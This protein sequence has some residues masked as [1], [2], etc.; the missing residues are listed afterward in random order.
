[1]VERKT[2]ESP[3]TEA[4][5]IAEALIVEGL[6]AAA[7]DIPVV[8]EE[9]VEAGVAPAAA[10]ERRFW[11]VDPLDGTK[12]F[13]RGGEE[14]AVC[15]GLVEGGR[16]LLG[17]IAL[18]ATG[19]LFGGLVGA[20][21]WKETGDE[22]GPRRPLRVRTVPE[23]G[24]VA[25]VSR[26]YADDP[27]LARFLAGRR[28][29]ERRGLSSALKFCRV[30]EG[31]ADI[32]ARFGPTME[33]DSAA[34]QAIVEAAGGAVV[35]LGRRAAPLR[36]GGLAQPGLRLPRRPVTTRAL[37]ASAAAEAAALLRG[38]E[39]VAFPTETVYGLGADAT[40]GRA[41]AA[42][43]A[44]KGRPRFNPLICHYAEA[45]AA[46]A[47]AAPDARARLLAERF[48]PGPLTMVLPRRPESRV[49]LLTGAGLDSLAVRVP[50]HPLALALLRGAGVPV[51]APSANRSGAVS[52]TTAAH[53]LEGLGGRIAAVLDGGACPVG[54]ES[55]VLDLTGGRAALLRP[56]ACRR[57]PSKR[58]SARWIAAP[59]RRASKRRA[60]RGCWRR[61]TRPP[62]RCA[63]AR[64]RRGPTRRCS[65]SG[66][67]P[68]ARFSPG[69]CPKRATWPKRRRASSPA[70]VG[71][72]RKARASACAASPPWRCP[73]RAWA[74]PSTTAWRGRRRRA[75]A[76]T[77]AAV[78]S[79]CPAG[80][81]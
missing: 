32:Y 35:D 53:V 3:V 15:I 40:N 14:Y 71:S 80:R 77:V 48:W 58:C 63:S 21:A 19:E 45:G 6:R 37:P 22:G 67:R 61:T 49:A 74:P 27:R 78:R 51:A 76:R 28:V 4:D 44:A 10:A 34:G 8:A 69:T 36:Q 2:D 26:R 75:S 47:D 42:V 57:R 29:A 5:R 9:E 62:C 33:W 54:V 81:V 18:P 30:A 13:A 11:L 52:P 64:P 12:G 43:F 56:A 66:R 24:M 25:L 65:A 73:R 20:G 1:V 38:G 39:L 31:E 60:G 16:A 17:A 72:T 50:A 68:R 79:R 46:F 59:P 41:V 70:C 23:A 55:T 7:P